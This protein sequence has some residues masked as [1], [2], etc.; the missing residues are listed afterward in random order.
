[1]KTEEKENS[2]NKR[3]ATLLKEK[4]SEFKEVI[5]KSITDCNAVYLVGHKNPDFDSIA[6]LGAMALVCKR[7]KKAPYI[8]MDQEDIEKLEN[9][10]DKY[11]EHEMMEK[12]KEKFVV[13]NLSDYE[14][15]KQDNSLLIVLDTNAYFRTPFKNHYQDFKKILV[16]DHHCVD[17]N[18]IKANN[19]LILHDCA[20]SCSEIMYWLLKQ[21]RITPSDVDYYTFLLIGINLDTKKGT[22]SN[23]MS[24]TRDCISELLELRKADPVKADL[25]LNPAYESVRKSY[26]L[27]NKANWL[28]LRYAIA[29][30]NENVY[31]KKEVAYAA[32]LMESF[33]CEAAIFC[34]KNKDGKYEVSARSN[35]GNVDI[36][37]IMRELN[38]GGGSL[39]NA[40]CDPIYIDAE[41]ELENKKLLD[42]IKDII[43]LKNNGQ[44]QK[45][46]PRKRYYI[47]SKNIKKKNKEDDE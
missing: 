14:S 21:Y 39:S 22:K 5:T 33:V 15:N 35:R 8:V 12:I 36:A 32:D 31:T 29:V 24:S 43:Y 27:F 40:S 45:Q 11:Y 23:T 3:Q 37:Y 9:D 16:L 1:M 30:D 19:K 44:K 38:G 20:S 13:I 6:S 47:K 26:E 10:N 17:D 7:L 41:G 46:M 34:G 25:F 18:T 42:E 2:K 28:T 4:I